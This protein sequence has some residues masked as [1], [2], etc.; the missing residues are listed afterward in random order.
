[1]RYAKRLKRLAHRTVSCNSLFDIPSRNAGIL[2]KRPFFLLL[3]EWEIR[4]IP[5]FT[6]FLRH[7]KVKKTK[8]D[9]R[10][11]RLSFTILQPVVRQ[12]EKEKRVAPP[13][14]FV[15]LT[16][17]VRPLPGDRWSGACIGV[18]ND[19]DEY[20]H[21]SRR[22]AHVVGWLMKAP[23]RPVGAQWRPRLAQWLV[24]WS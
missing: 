11:Y 4:R 24:H 7:M 14:F 20:S 12:M 3:L 6:V 8:E 21:A 1:M 9:C 15:F 16:G 2:I 19:S 10:H 18:P 22:H 23:L 13:S 5:S 17:G